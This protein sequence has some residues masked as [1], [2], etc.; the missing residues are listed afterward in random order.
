[1]IDETVLGVRDAKGNWAPN[2]RPGSGPLFAWPTRPLPVARW[3]VRDYLLSWQLLY[4]AVA[5]LV[6]WLATPARSTMAELRPGWIALVLL[7]NMAIVTVWYGVWHLRLYVRKAQGTSTK[8]NAK[9]PRASARFTLGHQTKDNV[10]WTLAS[11]VPIATA[12]EVIG[13]WLFA[14]G[15]IPWLGWAD[16]PVWIVRT[17]HRN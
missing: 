10:V 5:A 12:F 7:R 3:F 15:R 11:G 13:L 9:W 6:W 17:S 4:F 16:H 14:S 2:E 1:M 8:Y